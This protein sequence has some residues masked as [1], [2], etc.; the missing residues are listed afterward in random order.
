[1]RFLSLFSGIGLFDLGLENAGW[2]AA[3]QCEIE[4]F[5]REV[6]NYH[7][8]KVPKFEDVQDVTGDLVRERCGRIDAI[9]GGFP[10]QDISTAGK[11]AGL[12]GARSGLYWQIHRLAAELC[13]TWLLL[14][15]VPALR[16]RGADAVLLSLAEIGYVAWPLVVGA[17]AVGAPHRRDRVWVL[18][19]ADAAIRRADAQRWRDDRN[20]DDTGREETPGRFELCRDEAMADADVARPQEHSCEPRHNGE[21]RAATIGSGGRWPARPGE[22][23]YGWEE[24]RTETEAECALGFATHGSPKRLARYWRGEALKAI[25]NA[26]VAQIPEMIARSINAI[27]E[28]DR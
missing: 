9:V 10:C 2:E 26:L 23:Q 24:P 12:A 13:P 5:P 16:T 19:Y 11:G 21:E 20:R 8:P 1:M 18:A 15:N 27:T 17:W 14:E 28:K 25:G 7:W 6:L 22:S 3:G 4:A